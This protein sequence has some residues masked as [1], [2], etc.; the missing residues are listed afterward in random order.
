MGF[1]IFGITALSW[2]ARL[3]S[4]Q[5]SRKNLIRSPLNWIV[6]G[7]YV[8]ALIPAIFVD[9][10]LENYLEN[11]KDPLLILV[12]TLSVII[13]M[14]MID[15]IKKINSIIWAMVAVGVTL[16]LISA[17]QFFS[18]THIGT[19]YEYLTMNAMIV[20]QIFGDIRRATSVF[21]DAPTTGYFL[22]TF[23]SYF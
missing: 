7:L 8:A 6:V 14:N 22:Q 17:V 20:D 4:K 16:G 9:G 5:N 21:G 19:S 3:L 23:F 13:I 2:V 15:S 18:G 10:V 12:H 11:P 1:I